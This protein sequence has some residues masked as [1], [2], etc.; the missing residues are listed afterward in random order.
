[1]RQLGCF[2]RGDFIIQISEYLADYHRVFDAG[3]DAHITTAFTAGFDVNI[4]H[5]F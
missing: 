2:H 5:P 3:D 1:M 4:K